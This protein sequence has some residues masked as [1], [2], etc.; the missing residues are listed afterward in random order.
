MTVAVPC[1]FQSKA[2][3]KVVRTQTK[4]NKLTPIMGDQPDSP[5]TALTK[6]IEAEKAKQAAEDAEKTAQEEYA[7]KVRKAHEE[8]AALRRGGPTAT[9]GQTPAP[10]PPAALT[11]VT[12]GAVEGL[13]HTERPVISKKKPKA[14]RSRVLRPEAVPSPLDGIFCA[15]AEDEC[16]DEHD[17]A[18]RTLQS[19]KSFSVDEINDTLNVTM[20]N[21][22]V[23]DVGTVPVAAGRTA[24]AML[25]VYDFPVISLFAFV[26]IMVRNILHARVYGPRV[27]RGDR[28]RTRAPART[29]LVLLRRL[30]DVSRARARARAR[31][32]RVEFARRR[33]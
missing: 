31:R 21:G 15:L 12:P 27:V 25:E 26:K 16:D 5:L 14:D 2:P 4:P 20:H 28:H 23:R 1:R 29:A 9:A 30:I 17:D 19:V 18:D 32:V 11:T 6:Q 8:L 24:D 33:A 13:A 3:A 7:A 22:D 10:A